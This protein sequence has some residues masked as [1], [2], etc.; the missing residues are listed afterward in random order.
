[1]CEW[2][3]ERHDGNEGFLVSVFLINSGLPVAIFRA[4]VVFLFFATDLYALDIAEGSGMVDSS[5]LARA[6]LAVPFLFFGIHIG[7]KKFDPNQDTLY[8]RNVLRLLM[9]I[10]IILLRVSLNFL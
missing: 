5:L 3:Y 10:A 9:I 7:V 2:F 6:F 4:S 1:M 8:K